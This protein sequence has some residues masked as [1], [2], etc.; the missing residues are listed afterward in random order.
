MPASQVQATWAMVHQHLPRC[1]RCGRFL[2]PRNPVCKNPSCGMKG[3]QQGEPRPWPPKGVRFTTDASKVGE[4]VQIPAPVGNHT[5]AFGNDPRNC[6]EFQMRVV[7]LDDLITSNT[8]TGQVNPDYDQRLQPRSRSRAASRLQVDRIAQDLVPEALVWDFHQLDKGPPIIGDDGMV[9]S[10]NGRVMALRRVAEAQ[11]D[12]WEDYQRVIRDNLRGYGITAD[13]VRGMRNPV[14][15]RERLSAVDRARFAQEANAPAVLQMSPLEQALQDAQY[16]KDSSLAL[17]AIQEGQS[18]D[19]ALR[20]AA[21]RP[22]VRQFVGQ[23]NHNDQARVMRSDGTLNRMG[24]WRIKAA[25][26]AKVFPGEAGERLADT[27]FESVDHSTRNFENAISDVMPRLARAE[28]LMASGQR[29]NLSLAEDISRAVDMHARLK[30]MGMDARD[31]VAQS[32]MFERELTPLQERLLVAFSDQSRSRKRIR[33][34]LGAYADAVIESQD[35]RQGTM[36]GVAPPTREDLVKR[37]IGA[38]NG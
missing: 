36:F 1:Q 30:E 7:E 8:S 12:R 11:P 37:M 31:Y 34:M 5:Q 17:F 10:G 23:L 9:E 32:S 13:Q 20:T 22:F 15:V 14:L 25:M 27:F 28:S 3:E 38:A 35:P 19:Q 26:F 6:Y 18:I 2:S 21:N 4:P 29:A 33:E 24:L 16:V